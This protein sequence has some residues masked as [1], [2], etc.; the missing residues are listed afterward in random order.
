LPFEEID[1]RVRSGA[2]QFHDFGSFWIWTQVSEHAKERTLDVVLLL[3][4]GFVGR[5]SEAVERLSV[6]AKE[7]GC[8]AIEAI[9]RKGLAP[10]LKPIGFKT[11]RVLL[12]KD[13]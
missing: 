8:A 2:Y 5:E 3:G 11:T 13:L 4:D 10:T 7:H 9:S 6:F 1:N 12:R